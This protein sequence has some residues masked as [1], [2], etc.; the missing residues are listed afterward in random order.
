[1]LLKSTWCAFILRLAF[2][3]VVVKLSRQ[4]PQNAATS[5]A[6]LETDKHLYELNI[7]LPDKSFRNETASLQISDNSK[8]LSVTGLIGINFIKT[9][10]IGKW[11]YIADKNGFVVRYI[12]K[13]LKATQQDPS[14]SSTTYRPTPPQYLPAPPPPKSLSPNALKSA[15]G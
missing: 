7:E 2:F 8:D 9:N 1:M 5:Q 12:Y 10:T 6:Q 11:A 3:S 14:Y 4:H 13:Q 15:G